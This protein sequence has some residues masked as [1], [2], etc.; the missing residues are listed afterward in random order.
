[1]KLFPI[2][3]K[4]VSALLFYFSIVSC[5]SLSYLT[6]KEVVYS[7]SVTK[8]SYNDAYSKAI[9]TAAQIGMSIF[10]T[11][12]ESGTFYASKGAGLGE[13]SEMNYLLT[14]EDNGK[15]SMILRIKS[16]ESDKL[17]DCFI[18]IYGKSIKVT[19]IP[20]T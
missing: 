9:K 2:T 1:M 8:A 11:D 6:S 20:K 13:M 14:R 10:T 17:L 3:P 7:Y 19:A 15:L 18:K 5:A 4:I 16:S 12:K